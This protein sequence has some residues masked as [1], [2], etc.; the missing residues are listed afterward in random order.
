MAIIVL[1]IASCQNEGHKSPTI[2]LNQEQLMIIYKN[3]YLK[4]VINCQLHP[5]EGMSEE[6][7]FVDS[8]KMSK[9]FFD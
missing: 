8:V 9:V 7:W 2:E 4:G 5:N 6:T 1:V 3:G